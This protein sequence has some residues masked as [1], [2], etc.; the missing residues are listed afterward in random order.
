MCFLTHSTDE[1]EVPSARISNIECDICET[2]PDP[3]ESKC[4][5]VVCTLLKDEYEGHDEWHKDLSKAS[6]EDR[7]KLSKG[8]EYHMSCLMKY[9]VWS[10]HKWT[11][12]LLIDIE[13]E[14]LEGVYEKCYQYNSFHESK[15]HIFRI[16]W[17]D[18]SHTFKYTIFF[19]ISSP[20]YSRS[21][22]MKRTFSRE[23]FRPAIQTA[24]VSISSSPSK[25]PVVPPFDISDT[26][27]P[28][29]FRMI[30]SFSMT[31]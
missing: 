24:W 25:N 12:H 23:N 27:V 6:S 13:G 28:L 20:L 18:G 30:P 10:M 14:E 2:L 22:F 21:P 3:P 7:D 15:S 29:I 4:S 17:G 8:H 26:R 19:H 5:W 9:Q 31:S 16:R 1:R 11:H